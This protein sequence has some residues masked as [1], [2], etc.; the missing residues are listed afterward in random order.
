MS[1]KLWARYFTVS[2]TTASSMAHGSV[3]GE[4]LTH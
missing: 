4:E 1:V 3:T 2:A